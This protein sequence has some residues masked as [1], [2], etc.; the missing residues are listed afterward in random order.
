[1][2]IGKKLRRYWHDLYYAVVSKRGEDLALHCRDAARLVNVSSEETDARTKL[3][4]LLHLSLCQACSNYA[5]FTR[6]L[7]DR[8][9][10]PEPSPKQVERLNEELVKKLAK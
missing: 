1:M 9:R 5:S 6:L 10:A 3:R 7:R 4:L 8:L 2:K